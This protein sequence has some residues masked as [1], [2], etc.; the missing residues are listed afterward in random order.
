MNLILIEEKDYAGKSRVRLR[1]RALKHAKEVFKATK[2][3]ELTVG[4]LNGK[5]GKGRV[6][7]IENGFLD[8][9]LN[10]HSDPP[11]PLA[12]TLIIA[13]PRPKMLSRVLE[14]ATSMGV[15]DMYIINS[16]RVEKSYW[17]S[18]KLEEGNIREHL[19]AGLEQAKDTILP[20]VH[21]RRLFTPFIR[22]ELPVLMKGSLPLVA[23]PVASDSFP[24]RLIL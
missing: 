14:S 3:D 12:V 24:F 21:L 9:E 17:L 5:M 11:P 10:L 6:T 4:L 7:T 15:K 2:G 8:M 22:E 19:I 1:G 13:L 16:W 18:P 20:Q 23:H